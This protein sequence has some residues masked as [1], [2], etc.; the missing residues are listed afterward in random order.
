MDIGNNSLILYDLLVPF[1]TTLLHNLLLGC[2][3]VNAAYCYRRSTVVCRLSVGRSATLSPA[4]TAEQAEV[5]FGLWTCVGLRRHVLDGGPDP[6]ANGKFRG[7][8]IICTANGWK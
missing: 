7:E 6:R 2:I 1:L 8:N 4:K 5:L 3:S